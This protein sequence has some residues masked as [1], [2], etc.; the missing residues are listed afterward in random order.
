[1]E[2]RAKLLRIENDREITKNTDGEFLY[3]Y[4]NA[5]LLALKESGCLSEMQ[6]RFAEEKLKVQYCDY[7]GE[8]QPESKTGDEKG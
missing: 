8:K 5:L 2:E 3:A 1:M 6:Y 4:Q 7:T